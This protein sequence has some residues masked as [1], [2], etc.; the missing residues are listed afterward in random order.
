M[1]SEY[2]DNELPKGKEGVMFTHL[3]ICQECREEFRQQNLIQHSIKAGMKKVPEKLE[4]HIYQSIRS[5]DRKP[6]GTVFIRPVPAYVSYILSIVILVLMLFSYLQINALRYDLHSFQGRYD[7]ALER[8][9]IQ[10]QQMN[11]MMSNMPAVKI[12]GNTARL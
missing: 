5:K 1:I 6:A 12:D 7:N 3:S 4:E 2:L 8:I 11:I 9:Q 10:S